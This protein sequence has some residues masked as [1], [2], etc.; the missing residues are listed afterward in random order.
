MQS[1]KWIIVT[2]VLALSVSSCA[3]LDTN[4]KQGT[5]I[6]VGVGAAAGALLGQAIGGDTEAT[7]LGAG[8]GGALGGLAGNQVGRYMDNQEREL[9]NVMAR[10]EAASIQRSQDVLTATF[11]GEA[12]FE[13]DSSTL[14]PGAYDEIARMASVLNRY[15]QTQIEVGGHT[16]TRGSAEYNQQLSLRRARAVENALIQQGV[17]P[18]R[19]RAVGYGKSRPVSS[20]HAMNRRVEVIIIPMA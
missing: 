16:D 12:F 14:L 3:S 2:V 18:Q 5:A 17:A 20:S 6:G 10:S 1:M 4:Q 15:P 9:R 7:L 11:R 19:I 8:I 13:Y